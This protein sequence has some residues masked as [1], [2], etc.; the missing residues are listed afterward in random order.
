MD[1]FGQAVI[2][3]A[4]MPISMF[5]QNSVLTSVIPCRKYRHSILILVL[6]FGMSLTCNI[7]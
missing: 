5:L 2:V 7:V 1:F 6:F 3:P 4:T